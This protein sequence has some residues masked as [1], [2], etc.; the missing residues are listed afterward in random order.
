MEVIISCISVAIYSIIGIC[1]A[2][3]L[4]KSI[5]KDDTDLLFKK[6][7]VL[8]FVLHRLHF[9]VCSVIGYLITYYFIWN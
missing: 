2:F 3:Y 5:L 9:V 6:T 1:I 7:N 4:L 8:S